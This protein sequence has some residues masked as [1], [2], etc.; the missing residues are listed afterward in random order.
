[1]NNNVRKYY[2]IIAG[3]VKYLK[4]KVMSIL[5]I[6]N[7]IFKLLIELFIFDKTKR[8]RLK[9]RWAKKHLKKYVEYA[10]KKLDSIQLS[11][12]SNNKPDESSDLIWQYWHQGIGNAPLL[13]QKCVESTY[14]CHPDKKIVVLDYNKVQDYIKI[15]S[16]YY[17]LVNCGKMSLAHFSDILRTYLLIQYGGTWV[18]ATIFFTG[19]I[20]ESVFKSDFFVLSKNPEKD[21]LENCMS[22]YFIHSKPHN[23]TMEAIK[24]A[25]NEYW[26]EN[27]FVINYFFYEH[28]ATMLS[29]YKELK[30]DWEN[31][32]CIMTNS[33]GGLRK[34]LYDKYDEE[35]IDEIKSQFMH[36]LSYK[37]IKDSSDGDT[38]YD[39]IL[40]EKI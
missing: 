22:N 31:M 25:L 7:S 29:Q 3:I 27:N 9:S 24:F 5:K 30:D 14:K 15:P 21:P 2:I 1:M 18:D 33:L 28:I 6:K 37:I 19:R 20:Q 16:V 17:D 26:R 35:K 39:C 8:S 11:D 10:V 32:P 36:K 13:M 23:K 40:N 38:Y 34:V 4:D 12:L